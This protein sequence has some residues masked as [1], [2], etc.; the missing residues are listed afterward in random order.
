[1]RFV[2]IIGAV[3]L[4]VVASAFGGV[5]LAQTGQGAQSFTLQPGGTATVTF[6][7]FCTNFGQAFPTSIQAPNGV[8]DAKV[9][10]ALAYIQSNNL[11]ADQS[12]ALEAQY[13]I[14][15]AQGAT[16]SPAGGTTAQA[17][18]GAATA[19]P[20]SPQGTSLLDAAQSGQV[21]VTLSSWQPVGNKVQIGNA[22]DNFYGRGTLTVE[23]T[24][25]QALTLYMP[26]GTLF[27]PATAG[28][29]TMAGYATSTQV[30]NPQ[31][32]P[33]PT[34]QAAQGQPQ[35][36]PN[37]GDGGAGASWL[38]FAGGLALIAAGYSIRTR[39]RRR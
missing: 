21:R 17:V 38:V 30:T 28:D 13:G 14:W 27:P 9:A 1:M 18:A 20:A 35:Q 3:A 22:S 31:P 25:Q 16:G 39:M 6:E 10:G 8:A 37:T 24:S 23:N 29:Q 34:A 19:A 5:A 15:Q 11:A 7:A 12:Q 36:L 4:A 26:V 2:R 32:T 33:Q